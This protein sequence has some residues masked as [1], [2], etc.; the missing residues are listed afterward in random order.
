MY[1][2]VPSSLFV[3]ASTPIYNST[4]FPP[5][6]T[7]KIN[8][9]IILSVYTSIMDRQSTRGGGG[10]GAAAQEFGHVGAG[11]PEVAGGA[12]LL[13]L[14]E[15][16]PAPADQPLEAVDDRLRH[17]MRSLEAEIG[18]MSAP[19][20]GESAPDGLMSESDD[21]GLEDMLSEFDGSPEAEAPLQLAAMPFEYWDQEAPPVVMG[22]D[23]GGWYVDGEGVVAGY[24]FREPCYYYTY[25]DGSAVEQVYSP[26]CLWE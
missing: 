12:F 5:L 17:V 7:T 25:S 26:M 22:S 18:G 1:N 6:A 24:E 8:T 19:A 3:A 10:A 9:S 11:Q 16:T 23:M 14:L 4:S 13:E 15:D 20:A 2:T 21:G